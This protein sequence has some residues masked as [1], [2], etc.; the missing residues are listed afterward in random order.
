MRVKLSNSLA[1]LLCTLVVFLPINAAH[2]SETPV[3]IAELS[4][5]AEHH[6]NQQ[7]RFIGEVVGDLISSNEG[8][9]WI[10]MIDDDASISVQISAQIS[11]VI[12][13]LGNYQKNGTTLEVVGEFHLAC[14]EHDSLSDVHATSLKVIDPGSPRQ[15][16]VNLTFLV[17]GLML[18][19]I[20]GGLTVLYNVQR[21]KRR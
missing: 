15:H 2:A 21:K 9:Y 12:S 14:D 19:A 8:Y 7:L 3:T 5:A 18:L 13:N 1:C 10:T 17:A 6:D 11:S 4:N 20:G 16:A